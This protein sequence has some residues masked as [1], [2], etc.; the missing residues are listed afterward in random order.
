MRTICKKQAAP[1][2]AAEDKSL[3]LV[4]Q[5]R[6]LKHFFWKA[7]R[8]REGGVSE[9]CTVDRPLGLGTL[10]DCLHL[11]PVLTIFCELEAKDVRLGRVAFYGGEGDFATLHPPVDDI[12]M[13]VLVR[14]K[15]GGSFHC[16]I[17]SRNLNL[18]VPVVFFNGWPEFDL[19]GGWQS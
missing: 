3:L 14:Q 13:T 1:F 4:E 7:N 11:S 18:G 19:L 6:T 9:Y 2:G 5:A 8:H 17:P 10:P 16:Q 12:P 15:A